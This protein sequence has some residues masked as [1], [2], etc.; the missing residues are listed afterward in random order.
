MSPTT[1]GCARSSTRRSGGARS[2][3]WS[4]ACSRSPTNSPD[5]LFADGSPADLVD[6]YARKLPLSVIC[7]LLG[8]PRADRPKFMEWTGRFTRITGAV[9]FLALIPA[10]RV[11]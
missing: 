7:E 5:A 10:R 11:R 6:R 8:L 1:P 4:R 9:G 3:I 2:S